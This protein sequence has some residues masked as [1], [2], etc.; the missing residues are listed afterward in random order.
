MCDKDALEPTA[1][2]WGLPVRLRGGKKIVCKDGPAFRIETSGF[3]AELIVNEMTKYGLSKAKIKQWRDAVRHCRNRK[4]SPRKRPSYRRAASAKQPLGGGALARYST[5]LFNGGG[6]S[7]CSKSGGR[8]YPRIV[9]AMCDRDALEP[10]GRWWGVRVASRGEKAKV[11]LA[12]PAYQIQAQGLRARKIVSE[13]MRFGLSHR[14][15]EQWRKVL[16]QCQSAAGSV[17]R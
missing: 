8:A 13:M 3:R 15:V 4:S 9:V 2:W 10:V 5:G 6:C 7:W 12:G 11:C 14:K 16:S 17:P 1:R